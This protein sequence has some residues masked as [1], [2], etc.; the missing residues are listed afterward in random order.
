MRQLMQKDLFV[1]DSCH[2]KRDNDSI[3]LS[4]HRTAGSW[5]FP[6]LSNGEC[7]NSFIVLS[8]DLL[9]NLHRPVR[10]EH[11]NPPRFTNSNPDYNAV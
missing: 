8:A 10:S 9:N 1:I 5:I 7:R 11:G 4:I 2:A 6:A 3:T